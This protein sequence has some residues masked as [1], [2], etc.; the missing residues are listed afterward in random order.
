MLSS[1]G[2]WFSS[3]DGGMVTFDGAVIEGVKGDGDS[4]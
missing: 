2:C 3:E 1:V 4:L